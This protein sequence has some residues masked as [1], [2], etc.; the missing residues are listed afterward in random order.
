MEMP[1]EGV[2][3][4]W[5]E[6]GFFNQFDKCLAG[7]VLTGV[8]SGGM[9]NSFLNDRS[10]EIVGPEIERKL[11]DFQSEH[12]PEGLYVEKIVEEKP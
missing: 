10:V 7:E 12:D 1:V 8:G 2:P 5:G 4:N 3:F 11:G 9:S 6:T